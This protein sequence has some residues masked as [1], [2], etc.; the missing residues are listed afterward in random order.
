MLSNRKG[1]VSKYM[2]GLE[3]FILHTDHK[4]LVPLIYKKE[5]IDCPIQC[6]CL[7]MRFNVK[8][9]NIP[10]KEMVVADKKKN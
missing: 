10:G 9:E 7:L 3:M 6:Q 1:M 8:A 5:L 2:V 4:P